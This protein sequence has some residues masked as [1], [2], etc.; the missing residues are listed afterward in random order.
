MAMPMDEKEIYSKP[1]LW[2][3]SGL[4]LVELVVAVAI[5]GVLAAVAV[6]SYMAD[7]P[8]RRLAEAARNLYSD[9]QWTRLQAVSTNRSWQVVF[10]DNAGTN[11][12]LYQIWDSGDGSVAT[13]ADNVLIRTVTLAG[14]GSG[15][16][17]GFGSATQ[18]WTGAALNQQASVTYDSRGMTGAAETSTFITNQDN[19]IAYAVTV[20][21]PGGVRIRFYNGGLPFNINNWVEK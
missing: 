20:S 12:D 5:I 2:G 14:Y 4:T 1:R 10:V 18:N 8:R 19:S 16:A 13:A 17:Y 3:E 6:P 15:V 7:L 21:R 9:L 11:N